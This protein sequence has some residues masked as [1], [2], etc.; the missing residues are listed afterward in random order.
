MEHV[1]FNADPMQVLTEAFSNTDAQG[2]STAYILT[3][4][5]DKAQ[6]LRAV[7]VGD[8][9]F[10][11][12]RRGCSIYHSPRKL[13]SFNSPY[14]LGK[15]SDRSSSADVLEFKQVMAGDVIVTGTDG[16]FDNLIH[17]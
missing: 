2:S 12:L 7:N 4:T 6:G 10:V 5:N 11:V 3:L 15:N 9:G 13:H 14:Q 8:S 17:K 16:L 1:H